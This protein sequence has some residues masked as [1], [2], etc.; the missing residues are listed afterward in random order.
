MKKCTEQDFKRFN[1][2][3]N[4]VTEEKVDKLL[5]NGHFY[6]FDWDLM[7]PK[8]L[9]GAENTGTSYATLDP[10]LTACA[11]RV[12]LFDGSLLGGGDDCEWDLD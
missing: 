1:P 11:S 9:Y 8:V 5:S 7:G 10:M 6:C 2:P 3:N 4:I 12:T